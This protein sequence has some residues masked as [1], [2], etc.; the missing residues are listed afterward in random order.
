MTS[1]STTA[2]TSRRVAGRFV[3]G[4]ILLWLG[5]LFLLDNFG[6]LDARQILRFWPVILLAL[7]LTRLIAPGRTEERV[8]GIVL[9]SLGLVF[10]LRA[11]DVPWFRLRSIWP[12]VL[13][14]IDAAGN[15]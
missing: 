13:V 3:G 8:G 9:T 1:R 11:I 10:L 14:A 2:G 15:R 7:G 6:V 5:V 4:M 12:V